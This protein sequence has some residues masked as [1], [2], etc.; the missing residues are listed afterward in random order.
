MFKVSHTSRLV[1]CKKCKDKLVRGELRIDKRPSRGVFHAR[2]VFDSFVEG[3][4]Q[5]GVIQGPD[6][7]LG[8]D[9]LPP[10]DQATL[11][12]YIGQYLTRRNSNADIITPASSVP[13]LSSTPSNST[14]T[15]N[16]SHLNTSTPAVVRQG[17]KRRLPLPL[18]ISDSESD[19]PTPPKSAR[20]SPPP[21]ALPNLLEGVTIP[22]GP[23]RTYDECSVCLDLPVHPVTLP[24]QHIFCYLCA[25][26]LT[27][28]AGCLASCSLCRSDIPAGYL[29]CA[30]VLAKTSMEMNDTPPLLADEEEWQWFYEGRKGWWR[31]EERN[32]E[33]LEE[34]F[35]SGQKVFETMICGNLYV[36]DFG[37]MEQ[38]QKNFPSRKRKIKRDSRSSTCQG[39]AGLQKRKWANSE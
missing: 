2:C 38:F 35:T 12:G 32:N 36:I 5:T 29:E 8:W 25:K 11:Q 39:V 1:S 4:R 31:F 37:T 22:P 7:L 6:D 23:P 30:Q 18:V 27:R 21:P 15:P 33:E 28:Q 19:P 34:N 17:I 10:G 20:L 13:T 24:C 16:T 9:D 3:S 14:S 26:G